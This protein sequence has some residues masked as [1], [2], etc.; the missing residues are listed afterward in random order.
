M[1]A[2]KI[3]ALDEAIRA[4]FANRA[5]EKLEAFVSS[6]PFYAVNPDRAVLRLSFAT[7]D[8]GKIEGVWRLG[9]LCE[10]EAI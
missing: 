5:I 3:V 10:L 1:S 7:A 8:L 2:I 9:G 4:K 6:A